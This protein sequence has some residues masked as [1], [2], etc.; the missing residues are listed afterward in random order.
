MTHTDPFRPRFNSVL[1]IGIIVLLLILA[2][3]KMA[4]GEEICIPCIIQIESSGNPNAY[5]EKSGAIGLMQ[6]TKTCLEDFNDWS[7]RITDNEG[8]NPLPIKEPPRYN[9]GDMYNPS[10]NVEVGTWYLNRIKNH[11]LKGKGTIEDILICYNWG[12]GNWRKWKAGKVKL[13]RETRN[14]IKRYKQL[15]KGRAR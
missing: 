8:R 7:W 4:K 9:M 14:Y 10:K 3:V 11:Y 15:T 12:Y 6:I 1:A 2:I 5:N 13:P